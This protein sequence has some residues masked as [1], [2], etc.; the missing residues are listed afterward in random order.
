MFDLELRN[1]LLTV[2]I[3]HARIQLAQ[4]PACILDSLFGLAKF[5][6]EPTIDVDLVFTSG[7]YLN[8]VSDNPAR[9]RLSLL[10]REAEWRL[11]FEKIFR[12][13]AHGDKNDV[14]CLDRSAF[15][16]VSWDEQITSCW[17]EF[18]ALYRHLHNSYESDASV[19]ETMD[20]HLRK[21]RK[22]PNE[23]TLRFLFEEIAVTALWLKGFTFSRKRLRG[24]QVMDR[25]H[26]VYPGHIST[27]M[28]C[29]LELLLNG[30]K[31]V[32]QLVWINT[33]EPVAVAEI[34]HFETTTVARASR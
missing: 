30:Q 7:V 21:Y 10:Q 28:L 3:S 16:F 33:S 17:H 29:G 20:T 12:R 32:R 5:M 23:N 15:A 31:D 6:V 24:D 8:N 4:S 18:D 1:Q 25:V 22:D 2:P 9:Q 14:F 27:G 19:R 11:G 34:Y 26:V 13:I